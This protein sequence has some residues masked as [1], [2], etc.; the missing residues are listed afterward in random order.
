MRLNE[1]KRTIEHN[2]I[3]YVKQNGSKQFIDEL[4]INTKFMIVFYG[5]F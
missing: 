5:I 2:F 3:E 1:S 4:K